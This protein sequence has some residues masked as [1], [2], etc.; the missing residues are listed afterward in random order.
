M[1][2][3]IIRKYTVSNEDADEDKKL[4]V[5]EDDIVEEE[6]ENESQ[7][8]Q[9]EEA[10]EVEADDTD[11]E[12][13][14][15][16]ANGDN[17]VLE[18]P[19]PE[20]G[21]VSVVDTEDE[22]VASVTPEEDVTEAGDDIGQDMPE[23]AFDETNDNADITV[24]SDSGGPAPTD[25][26]AVDAEAINTVMAD[27]AAV[28]E[29]QAD[30]IRQAET[31]AS[32][33]ASDTD[34]NGNA[35]TPEEAAVNEKQDVIDEEV[36]SETEEEATASDIVA[37]ESPL[38]EMEAEAEAEEDDLDD[39]APL[40]ED[41]AVS[42]SVDASSDSSDASSDD[43]SFDTE[44][45]FDDDDTPLETGEVDV[46]VAEESEDNSEAELT[47]E[48]TGSDELPEGDTTNTEVTSGDTDDV[49]ESVDD[50]NEAADVTA[51]AASSDV[52]GTDAIKGKDVEEDD[53]EIPLDIDVDDS[54]KQ[55]EVDGN[56]SYS[57]NHQD[58][59]AATVNETIDNM[60]G[61]EESLAK[62]ISDDAADDN[63]EMESAIDEEEAE[64]ANDSV[65]ADAEMEQ[66]QDEIDPTTDASDGVDDTEQESQV[67]DDGEIE[68]VTPEADFEEGEIDL[69]DVDTDVTEDDVA[70]A[71]VKADDEETLADKDESTA[72]DANMTIEE[73][74]NEAEGLESFIGQLEQG[75]TSKAY[76]P[77]VIVAGYPLIDRLADAWGDKDKISL[78][79]Y[80]RND[81][82][83]LY[84]ASLESARDYKDRVVQLITK[85]KSN[86]Q[87][88]YHRPMV[89]KIVTR[90]NALQKALDKTILDVKKSGFIGGDVKGISG[91][92][93]TDKDGLIR[94]IADDLKYTTTI[95]TKGLKGNEKLIADVIKAVDDIGQSKTKEA[96]DSVLKSIKGIKSSKSSYPQEAFVKGAMMGNWK[97]DVK[98][99]GIGNSGIP[100]AVKETSGDR[101]TTF[102]LTKADLGTLVI[103]AKA[104]AALATKTADVVGNK[105]INDYP[106]YDASRARVKT[107]E[108]LGKDKRVDELTADMMKL[109][110]AHHDMYKF[111]VKH[112]IDMAEAINA[113]VNKAI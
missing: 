96:V 32:E 7:D 34:V 45:N 54:F 78:E 47:D 108:E 72:I 2:K 86:L 100:V 12:L 80:T 10:E 84:V 68:D 62:D 37:E 27:G 11:D 50:Q 95:A 110:K 30:I 53:S 5:V 40:E 102:K 44:D 106:K 85:L 65:D 58:D 25:L 79:D 97:L 70:E 48:E 31:T 92:I 82:D 3:D 13:A 26:G 52:N 81:L 9:S 104:Y 39:D 105:A 41:D 93:A 107:T 76:S 66:S 29:S 112:A 14:D 109:S 61:T 88:W 49:Q 23:E 15:E 74:Q 35:I 94:A 4:D 19:T 56:P 111:I 57:D 113:V 24:G 55:K 21:E 69:P 59:S 99:G 90:G 1:L 75:I 60:D 98:E 43:S 46:D 17:T 101:K 20:Q 103:M 77:S 33:I 87:K 22:V 18:A 71:E 89:T 63:T 42:D 38:E 16:E 64:D 83:L 8:E 91:Y 36:N 67:G 6:R 51:E 73:L 28:A